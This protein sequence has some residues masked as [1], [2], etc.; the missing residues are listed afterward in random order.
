M[1][2]KYYLSILLLILTVTG[3]AGCSGEGGKSAGDKDA[4]EASS[5]EGTSDHEDTAADGA[6][7][8]DKD[9]HETDDKASEDNDKDTDNNDANNN[10][11]DNNDA[12]DKDADDNDANDND[13]QDEDESSIEVNGETLGVNNLS[14]T[15][16]DY[17]Y[18][19]S[20]DVNI[21][22]DKP[23]KIYY[24]T[25]GTE[26]GED[27][28]LYQDAIALTISDSL[29]AYSVKAKAFYEDGTESETIVH[30]YFLGKNLD[31]RFNTL[32]FSVTTDP[33]NLYDY[34]YGIFV[35]GKLRDDYKKTN[36]ADGIQPNDPANYNMRGRE[37][38]R[39]VYL[40]IVEPDG[41]QVAGQ[42][43]GIR[44]YGG[45]SR[46]NNQ[47]SIKIFA[48]KEY[49]LKKNKLE[50]EFFPTKTAV[51]GDGTVLDSFKELVL[52]NSGNDNGNAY[53]RDEFF[54]TIAGQAGYL[55][56][57]AVRPAALF[58]NGQYQG[59]Y[60]IHEV[61][62]DEYFE[63]HYGDYT[64]SFEVL[65]GGELFKN[66]DEDS[67]NAQII[68][69]YE[70]MYKYASMDLTN[71]YIYDNLC[72]LIDVENYLSYYAFNIY[73]GNDDW[74]HN[75]YKTYRYFAAEGE[76]YREAPFDGK[77]RYLLHDT[78]FGFGIY[79]FSPYSSNIENYVRKNGDSRSACPLFG[80]LLQRQECREMFIKKS[81]DLANG[82]FSA[83]NVNEVLDDMNASSVRELAAFTGGNPMQLAGR[84]TGMRTFGKQRSEF[85]IS[86]Y[87]S[88]FNLSGTYELMV[89]SGKGCE[90]KINSYVTDAY[91]EGT[92]YTDID[93][94]ITT[95]SPA[96]KEF[97][98]WLVNGNKVYG[99][100]L[101]ITADRIKNGKVEVISVYKEKP[102]DPHIIISELSSDGDGDYIIL[103]NPNKEKVS[104][105]GY[106]LTDDITKPTEYPL[107]FNQMK[108]GES[109]TIMCKD[110][111]SSSPD[112]LPK[113]DFNLKTGETL[114]LIRKG[115]VVDEVKIPDIGD[116][117]PFRRDLSTMRFYEISK[118]K[119]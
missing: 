112:R 73:I 68:Q 53:I 51:G 2:T 69:D 35:E 109:L 100:E 92:Y 42:K 71:D 102:K 90:L 105:S 9:D 17:F 30:T 33:Y 63:D 60:W 4:L 66:S 95:V 25:D 39:P 22:S 98:Y 56:Y 110:N 44:T 36:P 54:Q 27:K 84:L 93:T 111:P 47:K 87:R 18:T 97:D 32:V 20:M 75:N 114:Y 80:K 83:D 89:R 24:T 76:V 19:D 3:F 29:K 1:K 88:F 116:D 82:A 81:L 59:F 64:G 65:E 55:D 37:S 74:P 118:Y 46:A 50:Y 117:N 45:W 78:D 10:D 38:E 34:E 12:D 103:Y 49:D 94:V 62:G 79:G 106:F 86:N 11:A 113:A 41:T 91:F 48:R 28:N 119:E 58:I 108:P 115:I 101:V 23:C 70:A 77:W 67:E 13:S 43:A 6:A 52:R 61:Y 72:E 31:S 26:P 104:A 5:M 99:K 57:E 21:M 15:Q 7:A 85:I 96:G 107:P 8:E 16:T 14:F 40:E